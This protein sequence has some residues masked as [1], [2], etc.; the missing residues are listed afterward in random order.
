M[1][2]MAIGLAAITYGFTTNPHRMWANLLVDNF[3]FMAISL[4]G[5]FFVAANYLAQAGWSAVIK[6]VPEAMGQFLPF[7]GVFMIIIFFAGG[8]DLYHWTHKELYNPASPEYDKIIEGKSGWLNMPFYSFRL[9]LY[10]SV[11]VLLTFML[12]RESMQEDL[13][14]GLKHY[15]RS[16][17]LSAIFIVFFAVSSSTSAWDFLMSVDTHWFSTLF[18]WY[19]FAGLFVTGLT[20]IALIIIYLKNNNYLQQVNE[21]HLHDMAKYMFA[22]SVFWAYLWFDQFMLIWYANFPEEVAYF[23]ARWNDGYKILFI[24]N[25]LI[26]FICPFLI[27]MTRDAKRK[28]RVLQVAGTIILFGHWID[29]FLMVMPGTMGKDWGIGIIEIGT[30]LGF[31]GLFIWVVLRALSKAPLVAQKHPFL[32]ESYHHHI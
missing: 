26:N 18:G 4:C 15:N 1:V 14:G 23:Y 6:R 7:A 8:H 16:M 21:N 27:L 31:A 10:F 13:D 19:T 30:F 5:T 29:V 12:R 11:W 25:F 28:M 22:F 9:F 3:Y 2:L 32:Q 20:A 24:G 17:V